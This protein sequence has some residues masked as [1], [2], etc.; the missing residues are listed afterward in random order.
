MG[1]AA[2]DDRAF[3]E[4]AV[5]VLDATGTD[6][7]VVVACSQAT[8]WLLLLVAE[9]PERVPA[10]VSSGTNLPLAPSHR[11]QP[12]PVPFDQP[13][14]AT[15]GWA[16]WNAAYWRE[17]YEDFLRFLFSQVWTEPH[18]LSVIEDCVAW[19]L[20]TTPD[21]LIDTVMAPGIEDMEEA[22]AAVA[23]R[24]HPR[25]AHAADPDRCRRQQRG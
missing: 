21:T 11:A 7:A 12:D 14:R 18:S 23:E 19:E 17:H 22:R 13:Y 1:A 9:H 2:Y 3:A 15:D 25:H 6:Q 16:Q 4:D 24:D 8:S 5:A 10:A 20:E